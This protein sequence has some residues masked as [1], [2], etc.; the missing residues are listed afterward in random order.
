[1][2]NSGKRTSKPIFTHIIQT[3]IIRSVLLTEISRAK[4]GMVFK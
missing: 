4:H 3:Q 2:R 1:M